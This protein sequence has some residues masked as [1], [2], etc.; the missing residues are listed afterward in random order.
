MASRIDRK[1]SGSPWARSCR[2][3]DRQWLWK[4]P[5][6]TR[7]ATPPPGR[8]VRS[9]TFCNGNRAPRRE[10]GRSDSVCRRTGSHPLQSHSS[11]RLRPRRRETHAASLAF[12]MHSSQQK[13]R[14]MTI[15]I[16]AI[17]P[18]VA[19]IA[20]ILILLVPRILNYVVAIYLILIGFIGLWPHIV[21]HSPH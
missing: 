14:P 18:L 21:L 6:A 1:S 8:H 7:S 15:D 2:R 12:L 16:V 20:G 5:R 4:S 17:Q 19:L 13:A 11:L 9:G 3:Q 10:A